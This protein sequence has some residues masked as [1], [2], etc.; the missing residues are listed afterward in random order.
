MA[1]KH[2][3]G[4]KRT[5]NGNSGINADFIEIGDF[6]LEVDQESKRQSDRSSLYNYSLNIDHDLNHPRGDNANTSSVT[7]L[8]DL[9][10]SISLI[11]KANNFQHEETFNLD[12]HIFSF[13]NLEDPVFSPNVNLLRV[14][15]NRQE[16]LRSGRLH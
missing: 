16:I 13:F 2:S 12:E 6:L 5:T 7:A 10:H 4:F 15:L 3:I 8:I 14:V 1:T 11:F 9:I